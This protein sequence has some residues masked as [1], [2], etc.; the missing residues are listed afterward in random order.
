M[1]YKITDTD[2]VLDRCARC[3]ELAAFYT[4]NAG[5]FVMC[6]ECANSV[7]FL[8]AQDLAIVEW[9]KEQRAMRAKEGGGK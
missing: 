3:G 7:G 1:K 2:G 4:L 8:P 5:W 6:S 9:N